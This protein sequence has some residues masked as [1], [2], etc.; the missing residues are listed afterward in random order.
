M[1][2]DQPNR[3][4]VAGTIASTPTT[5]T[6]RGEIF[7]TF[8]LDILRSSGTTDTLVV[9]ASQYL[10]KEAAIGDHVAF[11]GQIRTYQKIVGDKSHLQI[12]FFATDRVLYETDQ[13]E[14]DLVGFVCKPP[15]HRFT[16][17]GREICDLM[18][19]VNRSKGKSDYIP[20]VV[21]GR[22]SKFASEL[23]VGDKVHL[24][25]RLQSRTYKKSLPDGTVEKRVAY[26]LSVKTLSL[27]DEN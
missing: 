4:V 11:E 26:E 24:T 6:C 10:L 21:W 27:A 5:F 3:G 7:N 23:S 8:K 14:M 25:G 19:A 17:L 2:T 9:T 20:C 13:N 22:L 1:E 18:I 12:A 16:P 15:Q